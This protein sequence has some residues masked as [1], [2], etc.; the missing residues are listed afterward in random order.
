MTNAGALQS[1][2]ASGSPGPSEVSGAARDETTA[3][4]GARVRTA[5]GWSTGRSTMLLWLVA[6]GAGKIAGRLV[7]A[8]ATPE[9]ASGTGTLAGNAALAE[10]IALAC[11]GERRNTTLPAPTAP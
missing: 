4:P 11:S 5:V 10:S 8:T 1:G 3:F 2:S 9:G 6:I 7:V